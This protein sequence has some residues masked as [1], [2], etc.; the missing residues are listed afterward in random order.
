MRSSLLRYV[1]A[2]HVV[3][4]ALIHVVGSSHRDGYRALDFAGSGFRDT[5]RI[6]SGSAP[7]WEDILCRNAGP[8]VAL[9]RRFSDELEDVA[10]MLEAGAREGVATWLQEAADQRLNWRRGDGK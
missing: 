6:G 9:L 1:A 3:A 8:V 4:S 2:P 7:M 5:T 10:E